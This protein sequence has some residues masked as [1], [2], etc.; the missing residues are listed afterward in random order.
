MRSRWLTV[1][2]LVTA[3]TM[4]I[5]ASAPDPAAAAAS[6]AVTAAA[7]AVADP[8]GTVGTA[9]R[10]ATHGAAPAAAVGGRIVAARNDPAQPAS[11]SLTVTTSAGG[12]TTNRLSRT[13]QAAQAALPSPPFTE[14]P[15]AGADTSCAVL[16]VVDADGQANVLLDNS[17]GPF[18]G[19]DDTL[20][21]V[22]N[23]SQMGL[24]NVK[25]TATAPVFGF[26]GDGLCTFLQSVECPFGPTGYEGPNTTFSD[27]S[28]DQTSGT[29]NFTG[30]LAPGASAYFSLEV[31]INSG[32]IVKPGP[33]DANIQGGGSQS[34][35]NGKPPC[36]G[37]P[38]NCLN[39][40]F[41]HTFTDMAVPGRGLPLSFTRTYSSRAAGGTGPLGFGWTFAYNMR[42]SID[43][44]GT[45]TV[46]EETGSQIQFTP[47]GN[48][49]YSAPSFVVAALTRNSD[50]TFTLTRRNQT[51]YTFS[52]T[53]ALLSESDRSGYTT[54]LGYANGQLVSVT[55]P[56]GRQLTLTYGSAGLLIGV[57]DPGGRIASFAYDA[58]GNLQ[59]AT[60]VGGGVTTFTY[61]SGHLLLTATDPRGGVLTNVYDSQ[62]RVVSQTDPMNRTTTFG[63]ASGPQTTITH[64][65]GNTEVEIFQN[66][67]LVSQT[68]GSGSSSAATWTYTYDPVSL[69]VATI[70]D[71]AGNRTT[72]TYDANG[73]RLTQRDPL[74]RTISHTYDALNDTTSTVDPLGVTTT[75][76]YDSAGHVLT[77]STPLSSTTSTATQ[78]FTYGDPNH[79]GDV[80][81]ITDANGNTTSLGYDA[82]G[83]QIRTADPA[84]GATTST[85]DALG[86]RTAQV[87]PNGNVAGANPAGFTTSYTYNAFGNPTVVVDPL[88]RRTTYTYDADQNQVSVTDASGRTATSTYDAANELTKTTRA[89]GTSMSTGRDP[90]GN[91]TSQ[92]DGLGNTTTYGYDALD[93]RVSET[94]PLGHRRSYTYD[95]AGNLATSVDPQNQTATFTYDAAHELVQVG[96]TDGKTNAITFSY[97]AAGQRTAMSDATGTS[98]FT[99]DSLHR[100]T[101]SV[102]GAGSAVGYGYDLGG[103]LTSLV[104]PGGS[105]TVARGYDP[106]GR[107][108]SVTDWLGNRTTFSYDANGNLL[109]EAY[110][111]ATTASM[112]YDAADQLVSSTDSGTAAG[113]FLNLRY[114][115]DSIGELTAENSTSYSYDNAGRLT[116]AGPQQ[117]QYDAADRLTGFTDSQLNSVTDTYDAGDE[118]T[119]SQVVSDVGTD[120]TNY[121]Y[122]AR[123]NRISQTVV[124]RPNPPTPPPTTK[125]AYD[126][127]NRLTQITTTLGK[128]PKTLGSYTYDGTGLRASKTTS[129]G[130]VAY[131]WDLADSMPLII[132]D[133][134]V[135]YVTGPGGLPLEQVT[136]A[137]Q[138]SYYHQDQLGSTRALTDATGH[139][140]ASY[141]YDPYGG[142]GGGSGSVTNPFQ[143]AGQYL[144]SESGL[145]YLR[146]R[147]YDPAAGQFLTR[148]PLEAQTGHPYGYAASNPVN[149][150]D[151]TGMDCDIVGALGQ[152]VAW[153]V[154]HA[155]EIA[156]IAGLVALILS[157]VIAPE[158]AL[159]G[160]VIAV[161]VFASFA[162]LVAAMEHIREGQYLLAALDIAGALTGGA[163]AVAFWAARETALVAEGIFELVASGE[164]GRVTDVVM[165]NLGRAGEL[166]DQTFWWG[167]GS[168]L[169]GVFSGLLGAAEVLAPLIPL[170]NPGTGTPAPGP[171]P[172]VWPQCGPPPPR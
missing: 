156:A 19:T 24:G 62:N 81:A 21:G 117:Y 75:M 149:M 99:Y 79:P 6:R 114:T 52:G 1:T 57:S 85:Y 70:T 89:D 172:C 143:F 45:V 169:T 170:P 121:T 77:K 29:V 119:S 41:Y 146:A 71:P 134:S 26:D 150:T 12:S 145:Y 76:T 98:T 120:T 90:N 4:S 166:V 167:L 127:T 125:F 2:C 160:L 129:G 147:Y 15:A 163:S 39:G 138:V 65:N 33:T 18:D 154:E 141:S 107:V 73:N 100:L 102:N 83:D 94:D 80:T 110:P 44:V 51:R 124:S 108:T 111:N 68:Y 50:G 137:N 96:F 112:A 86:R 27:V 142:R 157:V 58:A 34:I 91:I 59:S 22:L 7:D 5:S 17:Q 123:G 66:N 46:T 109:G 49:G 47:T 153:F 115:R 31:A 72:S 132:Q 11:L 105:H 53:G 165:E 63:Y 84:G 42:L 152:A 28:A 151:P 87:S 140:V 82:D 25:L 131:T 93:R 148:D 74:G 104:Y 168:A 3:G 36:F 162:S 38:V 69:G 139:V 16:I 128:S 37:S 116:A 164:M 23:S 64:P 136:A 30:G 88:G 20:V 135:S 171:T 61:D 122:D 10:L 78:R 35:P 161:T 103:R 56:A 54:R 126:Q 8:A 106:A 159:A 144:D 130:T 43:N 118:L 40:E 158:G 67:L 101:G 97:D 14:C 92:T 60:D 95:A 55:D 9:S 113:T 32:T 133:G 155:G 13:A 48:G